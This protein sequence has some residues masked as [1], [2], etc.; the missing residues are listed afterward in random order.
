[1]QPGESLADA[2]RD[3]LKSLDSE[4]N[5]HGKLNMQ[6]FNLIGFALSRLP[7]IDIHKVPLPRKIATSL[8]V[9]ISND[10]RTASLLALTGY[11]VQAITIV[12]SMFE[13]SYCIAAIGSDK[14]LAQKWV[15]HDTPIG[16]FMGVR[17]MVE[18]GLKNLGH[19]SVSKQTE[20]EYRV[21]RQLCMPKHTNPL[22]QM[23]YGYIIR[24]GEVVAMNGPNTSEDTVRAAWFAMEHATALAFIAL[25]C[26]VNSIWGWKATKIYFHKYCLLV[27]QE[28]NLRKKLKRDG[29]RKIHFRVNGKNCI[30][31]CWT[32]TGVSLALNP[33]RSAQ[34]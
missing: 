6:A 28:S 3:A 5:R 7:V 31:M 24:E 17:A 25:I 18:K 33:S 26:F 20:V 29:G 23:E 19:P 21:Y 22:F 14:D 30:T 15:D 32:P 27:I 1:M 8:L 16:P 34:R 13:S 12:S 4:L 9:K 10:L 2:E 11:A